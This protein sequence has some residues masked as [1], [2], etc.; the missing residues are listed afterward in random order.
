M[1]CLITIFLLF[2]LT[3]AANRCITYAETDKYAWVLSTKYCA[4][5]RPENAVNNA[6]AF[7][8]ST[9]D[10]FGTATAPHWGL[11]TAQGKGDANNARQ[12]ATDV[13]DCKDPS[14]KAAALFVFY[15]DIAEYCEKNSK[16]GY[17]HGEDTVIQSASYSE[18]TWKLTASVSPGTANVVLSETSG[19]FKIDCTAANKTYQKGAVTAGPYEVKC[20]IHLDFAKWG[21]ATDGKG[22]ADDKR[23]FGFRAYVASAT[24][25]NVDNPV[26]DGKAGEQ[27]LASNSNGILYKWKKQLQ[28]AAHNNKNF[29]VTASVSDYTG[30][31]PS[32]QFSSA[33]RIDFA[34]TSMSKASHP[35]IPKL[36]WDPSL[37]GT[38]LENVD[39][40]PNPNPNNP[41]PNPNNPNPNTPPA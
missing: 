32:D 34:F 35:T 15:S 12:I 14:C 11:L 6:M 26:K 37:E 7:A 4:G 22:C 8:L 38:S 36:I 2:A 40:N 10:F 16:V 25:D 5:Q 24:V 21:W 30:E 3:K 29:D 1:S 33:K 39:N 20:D 41:N 23:Y 31:K 28:D 19:V 9:G 27:Q 17:Q 13:K 18:T